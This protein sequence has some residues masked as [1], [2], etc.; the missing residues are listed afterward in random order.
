MNHVKPFSGKEISSLTRPYHL[1]QSIAGLSSRRRLLDTRS[2]HVRSVVCKV[3]LDY[4]FYWV[5]GFS[6]VS[7][8]PHV[9]DIYLHVHGALTRRTNGQGLGTFQKSML[10]RKSGSIRQNINFSFCP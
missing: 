4:V 3:A 9:P 6:P 5:L 8:I 1:I 2:V 7:I 10:F